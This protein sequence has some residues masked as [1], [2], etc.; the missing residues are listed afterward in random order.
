MV[1]MELFSYSLRATAISATFLQVGMNT[2]TRI[3]VKEQS[4]LN[5]ASD[6]RSQVPRLGQLSLLPYAERALV[7]VSQVSNTV[8]NFG[9]ALT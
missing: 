1:I 5:T 9:G 3:T 4:R 6:R 2:F 7:A 8:N